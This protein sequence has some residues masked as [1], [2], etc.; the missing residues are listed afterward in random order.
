MGIHI[1]ASDPAVISSLAQPTR[2][3]LNFVCVGQEWL[4]A[5]D[6]AFWVPD[7][8]APTPR[9]IDRLREELQDS[10]PLVQ[11]F[12]CKIEAFLQEGAHS[13]S[14]ASLVEASEVLRAR[15]GASWWNSLR[16]TRSFFALM[17]QIGV[18]QE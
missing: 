12:R 2:S 10:N 18:S 15:H 7:Y 8:F 5:G 6:E 16:E 13:G 17:E 1:G 9:F 14:W 3:E 4:R 11:E